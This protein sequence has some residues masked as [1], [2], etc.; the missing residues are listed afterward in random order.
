MGISGGSIIAS[1]NIKI[2][3]GTIIGAN[4]TIIDTDFH[5]INSK[6]RRYDKKNIRS[7]PVVIGDNVFV[8]MDVII[9]KGAK[10][11]NNTVV[12]AGSVVR[13][14]TYK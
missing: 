3:K 10:I 6:S 11:P 14:G 8:G 12:P 13:S 1:Q 7:A 2:G 4:S 9:L 5:P